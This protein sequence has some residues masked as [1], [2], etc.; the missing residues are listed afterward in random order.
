MSGSTEWVQEAWKKLEEKV[1]RNSQRI[2]SN[3]PHASVEGK[4]VFEAPHWWT[5]G[6][7]PGLLWLVYRESGDEN[8]KLIAE[9]CE[10]RL[11]QVL[12]NYDQ[13]D[14]DMGFM[15]T[16]TSITRYKLLHA[17]NSKRRAL[18]AANLLA[19]RFNVKG[20]YIRAWNPW[21]EDEDNSGWA[22]ID[23]LMNLPLLFWASEVTGDPRFKHVATEHAD[24]VLKHFIRPDGSVYHIVC[25]EAESGE[26][27]GVYRGQGFSQESAWSRG[28][29]WAL[30]GLTL[31][32]H[33]TGEEK[34]L[35]A[36]KRV[37][38]FFIANLPEDH[39]PYWD[40]RLPSGIPKYRDSSAGACG[41]CGLLLLADKAGF[42][43]APLYRHAAEKMLHSLYLNYG[44][45][46]NED[47]EGLILH[48][49]S[50]YPEGKNIDVP[51]IYGD[52][53]FAEGLACLKGHKGLFL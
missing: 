23:C 29:S 18:L 35:H 10:D 17:D 51:L 3:F 7:W 24:T 48:G 5:A 40:F 13:L 33:Y 16:L 39:V 37:A 6:F 15:W 19:G 30:Y 22:I 32:Y 28:T 49:T 50:H 26:W 36:A 41:A 43:E 38:Y 31:C 4:Y 53:F 9:Q 2:G 8:L 14:H 20:K 25:F 46:D 34:Y 47:E 45:W 12:T 21:R 44:A 42:V 11:D 1:A 52:Y 27:A